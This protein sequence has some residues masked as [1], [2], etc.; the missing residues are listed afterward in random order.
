MQE[1][2]PE[3]RQT[4]NLRKFEEKQGRDLGPPRYARPKWRK[5]TKK[6]NEEDVPFV[7]QL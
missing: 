7:S 5:V 4:Q 2:I 3:G 1:K 6:D